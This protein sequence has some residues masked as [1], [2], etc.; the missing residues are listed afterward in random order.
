M[1]QLSTYYSPEPPTRS[2][3]INHD[4]LVTTAMPE[5][6]GSAVRYKQAQKAQ[7]VKKE[8]Y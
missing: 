3:K 6:A 1:K 2:I 8:D 5:G 7:Q 4:T